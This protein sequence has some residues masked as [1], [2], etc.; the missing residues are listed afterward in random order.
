MVDITLVALA[1]MAP[2]V[3]IVRFASLGR[4]RPAFPGELNRRVSQILASLALLSAAALL[5][6]SLDFDPYGRLGFERYPN[7]GSGVLVYFLGSILWAW[8]WGWPVRP[9]PPRWWIIWLP[10][11]PWVL[12]FVVGLLAALHPVE[13]PGYLVVIIY[14]LISGLGVS[15]IALATIWLRVSPDISPADA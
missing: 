3:A 11:A 8:A 9:R 1:A 5:A 13:V 6:S 7:A 2:L 12:F 15:P 4:G 10:A 14:A